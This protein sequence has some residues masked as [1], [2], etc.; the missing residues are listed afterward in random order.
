[1]YKRSSAKWCENPK[2]TNGRWG[3]TQDPKSRNLR[4]SLAVT[5]APCALPSRDDDRYVQANGIK[6]DEDENADRHKDTGSMKCNSDIGRMDISPPKGLVS[7]RVVIVLGEHR[8]RTTTTRRTITQLGACGRGI[9]DDKT[10]WLLRLVFLG[11]GSY[12]G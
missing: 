10:R 8:H 3:S 5:K 2:H 1:M 11:R 12:A 4:S 7:F 9:L 6:V